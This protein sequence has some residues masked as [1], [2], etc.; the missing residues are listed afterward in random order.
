MAVARET[1]DISGKAGRDKRTRRV[2]SIAS[3]AW[4]GLILFSSTSLASEY[5]ERAFA[6]LFS[7]AVGKHADAAYDPLH[8][9]AE[10]GL[11]LTLFFV[12]A[13]LLWRVFS[14]PRWR[15][16]ATVAVIGL[17]VGTASELLQNFFP[18]RDPAIRD[19]FINLAGCLLGA[20]VCAWRSAPERRAAASQAATRG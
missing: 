14:T 16:V 20:A 19:V 8:F 12:L 10:K 17:I 1:N 18:N 11:H 13:M 15:R 2:W 7:A 9:L 5:C 3:A 4:I 6:W